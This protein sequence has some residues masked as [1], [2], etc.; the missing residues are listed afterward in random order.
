MIETE[1]GVRLVLAPGRVRNHSR[2][3]DAESLGERQHGFLVAI[4]L[5]EALPASG[6]T[7]LNADDEYV[8]QF[9]RD[10]KGKVVT[11]GIHKPADVRAEGILHLPGIGP[12]WLTAIISATIG[13]CI[14][15]F[16]L[17]LIKR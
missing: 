16:L 1:F 5:I 10:F 13:A 9:G 8:S 11:Y 15:L 14:L 17:R 12:W 2:G 4:T 6:A 7:V 3:S